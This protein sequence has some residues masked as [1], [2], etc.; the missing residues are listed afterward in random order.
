MPSPRHDTPPCA[1]C[2]GPLVPGD[3]SAINPA[4]PAV[5]VAFVRCAQCGERVTLDP[6]KP[7]DLRALVRVW[8]SAG[9]WAAQYE[10]DHSPERV[11]PSPAG[12]R[13]EMCIAPRPRARQAKVERN[14]AIVAAALNG[15]AIVAHGLDN[16]IKVFVDQVAPIG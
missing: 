7:D 9:A 16:M 8:W 3:G 13:A 6:S 14:A 1:D 2:G 10:F 12:V 15:I 5:R 11:N 4:D